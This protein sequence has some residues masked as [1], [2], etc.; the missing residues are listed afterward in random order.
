MSFVCIE[1]KSLYIEK[2]KFFPE[3]MLL[4]IKE[5][6]KFYKC[7][8]NHKK[9]QLKKFKNPIKIIYFKHTCMYIL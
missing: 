3:K 1:R 6:E 5:Y 8:R 9:N 4:T 7:E 2:V